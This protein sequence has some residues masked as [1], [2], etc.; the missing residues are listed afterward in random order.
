MYSIAQS[1]LTLCDPMA[2]GHQ[3]PLSM[4]LSHQES[5]SGLPFPPPGGLPNPGIKPAFPAVP[6]LTDGLFTTEPS[7]KPSN[8][9]GI[10]KFDSKEK[11]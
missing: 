10:T 7:G 2:V 6:A 8:K 11:W 4:G 3:A 1:C 5:W 9:I